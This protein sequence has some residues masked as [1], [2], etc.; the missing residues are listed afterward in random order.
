MILDLDEGMYY[1]LNDVGTVVWNLIRQRP[2][3]VTE[4]VAAIREEYE[5]EVARCEADVVELLG[6]MCDRGLVEIRDAASA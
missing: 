3:P 6:D 1:E 4:L 5:V 2:C